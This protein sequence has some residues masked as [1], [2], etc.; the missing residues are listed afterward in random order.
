MARYQRY[1][2][3]SPVTMAKRKRLQQK[4]S[5]H[6]AQSYR[7]WWAAALILLGLLIIV[8]IT[9][10][11]RA[12]V[13][14]N[15]GVAPAPPEAGLEH[16]AAPSPTHTNS[17]TPTPKPPATAAPVPTPSPTAAEVAPTAGI[18][19]YGYKVVNVYPH[20]PAAFTQGLVYLNDQLYEG[21]G[22]RG[23]STLRKVALE[24]GT[25]LQRVDLPL[26][27][28]GEGIVIFENHIVQLSWQER[29]GFIYDLDTFNLTREFTY[30]TEGWGITHNG[31]RLI[32]SD[33]TA[34][35]YF[36]D[37][38][39]LAEVGRVSV[40]D[41]KGVPVMRL[42][43]LEYING[44]VWANIWQTDRIA[45]INPV[46]GQVTGWINLAGLLSEEDR[47]GQPVDV[48]NGIAYDAAADRLFVTGKLWPKLFEIELVE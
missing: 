30:P 2:A 34:T 15:L 46:T 19:V 27:V 3:I 13:Q 36:W 6:A 38:N 8:G 37:P 12:L 10:Q 35:L 22:R 33:G 16:P 40:I 5:S 29:R 47:R 48:L 43:E 1:F 28:F 42:N 23:Q 9:P 24:S 44:E 32:M 14:A 20:D 17:P 45:R 39:T 31:Q 7:G 25:V 21:T 4:S 11:G 41:E 26:E 18:P